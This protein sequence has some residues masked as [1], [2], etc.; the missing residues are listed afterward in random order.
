MHVCLSLGTKR[1]LIPLYFGMMVPG[2]N[3][4]TLDVEHG[5]LAHPLTESKGAHVIKI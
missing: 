3:S 1:A 4:P 5:Q 2:F